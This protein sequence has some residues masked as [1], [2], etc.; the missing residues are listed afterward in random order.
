MLRPNVS[1]CVSENEVHYNPIPDPYNGKEY[2]DLGLPSGT[3][4]AKMNVGANSPTD[5]GL[6]FA[7][8]ETQGYTTSQ[9]GTSEGQK[10]FTWSDYKF[11]P[12][13]DGSTF[14][15]YNAAD[16]TVLDL[17]DDAAAVNWGGQWHM[18]TEA[19]YRELFNTTYVTNAWVTD[20]NGS[21]VNGRLFT[22][23]SNGN[24]MFIPAA[25]AC[26]DG[27]VLS[28]GEGG[29]FWA[30]NLSSVFVS[31]A[32]V[33]YFWSDT[34]DTSGSSRCGGRSVRGVVGQIILEPL[35]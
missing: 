1:H 23:V 16:G 6:Y 32:R 11:N 14:T 13:G 3:K 8:G 33:F 4:W 10:T 28:I 34:A 9:V 31:D 26:A 30:S 17:E 2:V 29:N 35:S 20:Y 12:S 22:S 5:T 7:W 25:G 18:P 19:Q 21:G 27:K 24:T 15:K